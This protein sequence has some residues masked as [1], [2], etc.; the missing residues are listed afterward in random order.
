MNDLD[1]INPLNDNDRELISD[2]TAT[3]YQRT[4]TI[5]GRD[6]DEIIRTLRANVGSLRKLS[7]SYKNRY[8]FVS[9]G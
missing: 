2:L 4:Q 3:F 7:N 6:E 8:C 9:K 5:I 1:K